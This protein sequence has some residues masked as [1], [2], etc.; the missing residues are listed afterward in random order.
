MTVMIT[1]TIFLSEKNKQTGAWSCWCRTGCSSGSIRLGIRIRHWIRSR[2]RLAVRAVC[3]WRGRC[4]LT[5]V[6]TVVITGR[7]TGRHSIVLLSFPATRVSIAWQTFPSIEYALSHYQD[8]FKL[9]NIHMKIMGTLAA[10]WHPHMV[11]LW[12]IYLILDWR[13]YFVCVFLCR[14]YLFFYHYFTLHSTGTLF[15]SS[16]T[17][18]ASVSSIKFCIFTNELLAMLA[19]S[20]SW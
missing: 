9:V 15:I 20:K 1:T 10:G 3:R 14:F 2:R 13:L 16:A 19:F 18:A 12:C 17:T 4:L 8:T 5:I 11:P 7:I 6:C